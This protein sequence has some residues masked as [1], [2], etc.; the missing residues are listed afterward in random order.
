MTSLVAIK[1]PIYNSENTIV[2]TIDSLLKQ[3]FS[4]FT[5]Y[6]YDNC[7]TD[8]TQRLV[9]NFEDKRIIYL[10]HSKNFGWN[11]NFDYCLRDTGEK[12]T[13]IAHGD[14]I[15][16]IDF[17]K[18]NLYFIKNN[19]NSVFFTQGIS[20]KSLKPNLI[21]F[22]IENVSLRSYNFNTL[23]EEICFNGNFLYCPTFFANS[24]V[25]SEGISSFNGDEFAGSADL[26]A[27]IRLSKNYTINLILT[28]GLFYHRITETQLSSLE[29]NIPESSFVK[30]MLAHLDLE[31]KSHHILKD[32]ILWHKYFHQVFFSFKL[33]TNYNLIFVIKKVISLNVNLSKRL[34]LILFTILISLS[35]Y[36]PK[37]TYKLFSKIINNTFR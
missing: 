11:Y 26:D 19:P 4:D 18:H 37:K 13:L 20:F 2:D 15:Y 7:S 12:Y 33:K 9:Q 31:I 8:G 24:K 32:Y 3:T 30:C 28:P 29:R 6:I 21:S 5:L 27:W 25:L 17:L 16:H 14:D 23:F 1:M 36:M 10:K 22:K 35:K 34:K